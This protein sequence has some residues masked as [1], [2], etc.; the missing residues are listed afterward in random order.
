MLLICI[1]IF[2]FLLLPKTFLRF[3]VRLRSKPTSSALPTNGTARAPTVITFRFT[4]LIFV[5]GMALG[6]TLWAQGTTWFIKEIILPSA[7]YSTRTQKKLFIWSNSM[8]QAM[9]G[10]S[11]SRSSHSSINQWSGCSE[12][13]ITSLMIRAIDSTES[14]IPIEMLYFAVGCLRF[15]F[16]LLSFT[17]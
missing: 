15:D 9:G 14:I 5:K 12:R 1:A 10:I 4:C 2:W 8:T 6:G 16:S 7:S 11:S 17:E 3:A 13:R